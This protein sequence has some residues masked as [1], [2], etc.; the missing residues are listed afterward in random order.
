MSILILTGPPASGKNSV[1]P[2]VA[3]QRR[4]CAVI[5]VDQV[6]WMLV[7]PHT[8]PWD[9]DEGKHQCRLGAENACLLAR[10][11]AAD[12]CDVMLLDFIWDYTLDIYRQRLE[13]FQP[14]II[15]LMPS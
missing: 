10:Q 9:G 13:P 7:Q 5:D 4:R 6:R 8:A 14:K 2:L 11:F 12:G 15:Q 1:A 3:R